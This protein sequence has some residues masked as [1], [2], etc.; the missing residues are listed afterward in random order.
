VLGRGQEDVEW[1][2]GAQGLEM[3]LLRTRR[4]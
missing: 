3:A 2:S 1:K 4:Y